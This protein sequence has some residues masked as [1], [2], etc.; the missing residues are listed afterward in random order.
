MST[1]IPSHDLAAWTK[2]RISAIYVAQSDTDFQKAFSFAFSSSPEI[3]L[4]HQNIP[5]GNMKDD[6][7]KR[8]SAAASGMDVKWENIMVVPKDS[9][10]LDE[11]HWNDKRGDVWEH[12]RVQ[13]E[14]CQ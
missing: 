14:A 13:G 4:N 2:A 1:G 5:K 12:G 8:R 11:V 7:V 10:K 6:M 3:F 9:A